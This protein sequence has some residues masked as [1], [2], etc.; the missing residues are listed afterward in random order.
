MER[1]NK[2]CYYAVSWRDGQAE[3]YGAKDNW[4]LIGVPEGSAHRGVVVSK[5]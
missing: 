1:M 2:S 4:H 5:K 3:E